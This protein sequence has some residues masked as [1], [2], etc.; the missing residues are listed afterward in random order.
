MVLMVLSYIGWCKLG[1]GKD[2]VLAELTSKEKLALVT[3]WCS[4][5][6]GFLNL[7]AMRMLVDCGLG[8]HRFVFV[9]LRQTEQLSVSG[10]QTEG[11][12]PTQ[13][14]QQ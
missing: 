8:L 4:T 14:I 2:E 10:V 6:L 5:H 9:L 13:F 11:F 7:V 1:L 3:Q 12:N